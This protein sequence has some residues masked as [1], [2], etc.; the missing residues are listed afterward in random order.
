MDQK[1]KKYLKIYSNDRQKSNAKWIE[2][3]RENIK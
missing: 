1:A 2:K 3:L